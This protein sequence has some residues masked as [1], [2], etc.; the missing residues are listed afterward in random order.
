[1][2]KKYPSLSLGTVQFGMDYGVTNITG[3]IQ[4]DEINDILKHSRNNN[5]KILDTAQ[6]YGNAEKIIGN[7]I[8][9]DEFKIISKISISPHDSQSDLDKKFFKTQNNLNVQKLY[10]LLI[11]NID[12]LSENKIN[13]I[14][15]WLSTLKDRNLV[16]KVGFSIYEYEDLSNID[17]NKLEII[18]I[19]LSIYDQRFIKNS[20]IYKFKKSG[21]EIYSRS[22]FLQGLLLQNSNEWPDYLSNKFKKHHDDFYKLLNYDKSQIIRNVLVFQKAIEELE[23][24]IFGVSNLKE[25][26]EIIKIWNSIDLNELQ[27]TNHE[28]WSWPNINDIDPRKWNM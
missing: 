10:G 7:L 5:I 2:K 19:P 14:F 3:K 11:H 24:V 28:I 8:K 4:I 22:I 21:L 6:G 23:G 18:Q 15:H 13:D 27:Y 17:I 9:K 20:S 12:K 1:M 25:L 16:S 26:I